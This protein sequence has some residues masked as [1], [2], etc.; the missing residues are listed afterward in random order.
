MEGEACPNGSLS[1]TD[2]VVKMEQTQ[3]VRDREV[4][5]NADLQPSPK[6]RPTAERVWYAL[7]QT[8]V[9][10]ASRKPRV[11]LPMFKACDRP[12]VKYC[13]WECRPYWNRLC[14]L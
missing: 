12:Y 5:V 9:T 14:V 11:L 4:L 3:R 1:R 2:Y 8:E 6:D 13:T 10:E 7:R